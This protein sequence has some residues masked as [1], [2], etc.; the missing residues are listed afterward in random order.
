MLPSFRP[1]FTG[2][3]SLSACIPAD[4]PCSMKNLY[5]APATAART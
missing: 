2:I 1:V 3:T 4:A 5:E